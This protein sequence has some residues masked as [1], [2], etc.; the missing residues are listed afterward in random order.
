M[1]AYEHIGQVDRIDAAI[2]DLIPEDAKIE[3]LAEGF[4]WTEGPLWVEEGEYVLFS[5]IPPNNIHKWIIR[6]LYLEN[7]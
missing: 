1:N 5:D 4:D 7:I 3:V 2:N 6:T